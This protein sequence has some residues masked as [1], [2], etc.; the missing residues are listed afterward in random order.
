MNKFY[1]INLIVDGLL[2]IL[3]LC[4]IC[5]IPF[6]FKYYPKDISFVELVFSGII[7]LTIIQIVMNVVFLIYSILIKKYKNI[8]FSIL[9]IFGLIGF[10]AIN[11]FLN[12]IMLIRG[13]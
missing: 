7:I 3:M 2:L 13:M 6:A 5:F 9:Y 12:M 4:A 1:K 10:I 11:Y 8:L